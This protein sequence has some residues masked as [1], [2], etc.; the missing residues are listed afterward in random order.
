MQ[1]YGGRRMVQ[2]TTNRLDV[3]ADE[4]FPSLSCTECIRS[5]FNVMRY[6]NLRF[7]YFLTYVVF[8]RRYQN[9]SKRRFEIFDRF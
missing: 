2:G 7:T 5:Y 4:G 6:L 3:D 8:T 1:F 9:N